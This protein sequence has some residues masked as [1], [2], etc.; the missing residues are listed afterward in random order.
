MDEK[1]I[2]NLVLTWL[3]ASLVIFFAPFF[4]PGYVVLGNDRVSSFLAPFVSSLLIVLLVKLVV[5]TL[6][7]YIKLGKSSDTAMG[8][9]LLSG[10]VFSVWLVARA[11]L[12]VGLGIASFWVA[13]GVGI[14]LATVEYWFFRV[15]SKPAVKLVSKKSTRRK[16]RR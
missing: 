7:K 14:I 5:M 3:V 6:G 16:K 2:K 8:L 9:V 15:S 10:Y 13:V 4:A 11:A 12:F 1:D